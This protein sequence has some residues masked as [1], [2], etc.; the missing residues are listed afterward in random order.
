MRI[1]TPLMDKLLREAKWKGKD[2]FP[3]NNMWREER[4]RQLEFIRSKC[5]LERFWPRLIC[6]IPERR[7]E[8]FSEIAVAYYLEI[9]RGFLISEW[10]PNGQGNT[11]G[12][13]SIRVNGCDVFCEVKSPGWEGELS[14]EEKAGGRLEEGK[15]KPGAEARSF[16]TW[17][18]IRFA[19]K[20]CYAKLPTDKPTLLIVV[21]DLFA[22]I[23]FV[24]ATQI[25]I[26][27]FD[28]TIGYGGEKGCFADATF[29]NLSGVL[30]LN[31]EAE[32]GQEDIKYKSDFRDNH[33]ST[34]KLR[35]P[36][37]LAPS[38]QGRG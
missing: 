13:F 34:H 31:L 8:T 29:E 38:R 23:T 12:E 26:A 24:P 6:E 21:D 27:L 37:P 2:A 20:K 32:L 9:K 11:K 33:Y 30:F 1:M 19:V 14:E 5:Q 16:C 15:W 28:E 36:L 4:E 22:P 10:E 17:E 35:F 3:S 7:D 18:K 25:E